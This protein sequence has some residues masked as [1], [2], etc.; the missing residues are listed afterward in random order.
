[1]GLGAD[2][3]CPVG[4]CWLGEAF[5]GLFIVLDSLIQ[6]LIQGIEAWGILYMLYW[7]WL[8]IRAIREGN[9]E[10]LINHILT[11]WHVISSIANA[12]INFFK[13]IRP[14]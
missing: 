5:D 3:L 10:P 8:V 9:P 13:L 2:L 4:F 14:W 12:F 6:I 7:I 11:V 1:M